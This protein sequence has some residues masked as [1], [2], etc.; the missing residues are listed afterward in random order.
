MSSSHHHHHHHHHRQHQHQHQLQPPPEVGS[1]VKG[2]VS[3]IESYGAFI[4]IHPRQQQSPSQSTSSSTFHYRGLLHITQLSSYKVDSVEDCLSIGDEIYVKVLQCDEVEIEKNNE[5]QQ[6]QQ[7]NRKQTRYK[8]SLSLKYASQD[9]SYTDLD[10][11]NEQ[12]EKEYRKRAHNNS[13]HDMDASN[14]NHY[15]R[16]N[17]YSTSSVLATSLNSQIGM[18][19]AVDPLTTMNQNRIQIR[20]NGN[21]HN[22][23]NKNNKVIINGYALV[24]DDEGEPTKQQQHV[25]SYNALNETATKIKAVGRGR[26][27]TLPS[28]MTTETH[29]SDRIGKHDKTN[30]VRNEEND[31]DQS[32]SHSSYSSRRKSRKDH[33]K[34]KRKRGYRHDYSDDS[35]DN[36][37][38]RSRDHKGDNDDRKRRRRSDDKYHKRHHSH[39]SKPKHRHHHDKHDSKSSKHNR[40]ESKDSQQLFSSVDEAKE[41]IRKLE[42]RKEAR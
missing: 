28:W 8:I 37:Y 38:S 2:T 1:I 3:R 15:N 16:S 42:K 20:N 35:D 13:N 29:D 34:K 10:P 11:L 25:P 7:D 30:Y 27:A 17:T 26:G 33:K 21:N 18:G 19:M 39:K 9:G 5:Q 24:G 23:N 32:H 22:D 36:N 12:Y 41:L 14:S 40:K 4:A 6:Q 31:D